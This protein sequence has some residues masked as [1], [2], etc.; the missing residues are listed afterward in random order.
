MS[1]KTTIDKCGPSTVGDLKFVELSQLGDVCPPRM[2]GP[3]RIWIIALNM[4]PFVR[5]R[6]HECPGIQERGFAYSE[7]RVLL[8]DDQ[9]S[10]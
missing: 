3:P 4:L 5:Y 8:A 7:R 2:L 10:R 6:T 9:A 1:G